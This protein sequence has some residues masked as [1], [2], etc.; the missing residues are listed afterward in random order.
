MPTA[1]ISFTA[2]INNVTSAALVGAIFDQIN[3]G[4][5]EIYLMLSTAGGNVDDGIAVYNVLR[6]L[7]VPLTT[8]NVGAI[9][10]IG[11][12]VF[13]SAALDRRKASPHSTFMFH[14][15][16]FDVPGPTRFEEKTLRERLDGL[17]ASQSKIGN[18]LSDRTQLTTPEVESLFLQA[19]TKDT[20]FALA[21]GIIHEVSDV[22]LPR[23]AALI[24]LVLQ[25]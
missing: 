14:G 9:N 3:R 13:L 22:N 2:D 11:N 17:T 1:Y 8:H 19:Q 23:G 16:G 24:Q 4:C 6:G 10:S 12:V 15:V 7:P 5:A 25:R 21:K 20:D 18:I